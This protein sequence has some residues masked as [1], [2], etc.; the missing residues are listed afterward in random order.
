MGHVKGESLNNTIPADLDIEFDWNNEDKDHEV[1]ILVR[2]YDKHTN[3]SIYIKLRESVIEQL[4]LTDRD[5]ISVS[6]NSDFSMFGIR[7]DPR[8]VQVRGN[9]K[10]MTA[11]SSAKKY[12]QFEEDTLWV[13]N[14]IKLHGDYVA[15][16]TALDNSRI[17]KKKN[18]SLWKTFLT[19]TTDHIKQYV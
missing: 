3:K 7:K 10:C 2:D 13:A 11:Q 14:T 9:A 1:E 17:E 19:S 12:N 15:C 18:D 16:E 5:S 8:G 4:Q 6:F